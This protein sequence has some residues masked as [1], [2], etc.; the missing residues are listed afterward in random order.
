MDVPVNTVTGADPCFTCHRFLVRQSL[1]SVPP[2]HTT[3]MVA[4]VVHG[5]QLNRIFTVLSS[6]K[7][8]HQHPRRGILTGE[9]RFYL[10]LETEFLV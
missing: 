10:W 8:G 7:P 6:S 5:L 9:V 1:P 3:G 4:P 2:I